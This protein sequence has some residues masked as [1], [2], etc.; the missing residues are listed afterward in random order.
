MTIRTIYSFENE[1]GLDDPF[2]SFSEGE[3]QDYAKQ[4]GLRCFANHYDDS[5][6]ETAFDF[7]S[8]GTREFFFEDRSGRG[9][10]CKFTAVDIG[11]ARWE[12]T[13]KNDPEDDNELTLG[14]WLEA[15][16]V[17]ERFV[18]NDNNF[19]LTRIA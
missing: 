13:Y 15:V 9:I 12:R 17:G 6:Q 1:D 4:H 7:T 10:S 18:H 5:K 14:E 16:D 19:T 3:A 8:S 11:N 2:V